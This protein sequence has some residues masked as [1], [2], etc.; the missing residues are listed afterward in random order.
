M[1]QL[2]TT[3]FAGVLF[4]EVTER[5]IINIAADEAPIFNTLLRM[6]RKKTVGSTTLEWWTVD[7]AARQTLINNVAGYD[8][9]ATSIAVDS[10]AAM[11]VNDV[12]GIP[13][14]KELMLI[15]A[16]N[17]NTLTVIRSVGTTDAAAI[18]DNDPVI[19]LG[20][21]FM[22][23]EDL[24]GARNTTNVKQTSRTQ[25][26]RRALELTATAAAVSLK[27]EDAKT[28]ERRKKLVE[29][30][31][32]IEYA[33][34][35]G[36]VF[37]E[38][39]GGKPR[40]GTMGVRSFATINVADGN[41]TL[42]E[43]ELDDFLSQVFTKGSRHRV[44]F[45]GRTACDVVRRIKKPTMQGR[46]ED[47]VIGFKATR[48]QTPDGEFDLARHPL[49]TGALDTELIVIDFDG[50]AEGVAPEICVLNGRDLVL[51]ENQQPPGKDGVADEYIGELGFTWG[52][53][54]THGRLTNVT[55]S[56]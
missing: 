14:T 27:G 55:A 23:G 3:A 33:A 36:E 17:T 29:I 49:M 11:R 31:R 6:G 56:G 47:S 12:I 1:T 19:N 44:V 48:Y 10:A 8:E 35:L 50:G 7:A 52:N 53:P 25:I 20:P 5:L 40:C 37:E 18:V 32:D 24:P 22:E 28:Q 13:R 42:T 21:F 46:P 45:G 30:T 26:F 4:P 9:T 2:S 39:S 34:L 15:T 41:G 16:I 51:K 43:P 54:E 38:T